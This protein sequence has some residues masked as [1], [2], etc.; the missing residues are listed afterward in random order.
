AV[1]NRQLLLDYQR[2]F[3]RESHEMAA[4]NPV[5]AYVFG[6]AFDRTKTRAFARLLKRHHIEVRHLAKSHTADNRHFEPGKAFVVPLDQMQYRLIQTFFEPHTTFLDSVFYDASAWTVA[7]AFDMP[8]ARLRSVPA[9]R[10]LTDE[11]LE[12]TPRNVAP[13]Q[14]AWVFDWSDYAAPRALYYLLDKG[15]VVRAATKPFMIKENGVERAFHYGSMLIALTDQ[16]LNPERVHDLVNEAGRLANIEIV[17][18]STGMNVAGPYLGSRAF[19]PVSKPRVAMVVGDG[20]SGYEAGEIWHLLDTQLGMPVTKVDLL[21]FDR[22]RPENY[23]A[24]I[25]PSGNYSALKQDRI[26]TLKNWASRGGTLIFMRQ[27]VAWAVRQGLVKEHFKKPPKSKNGKPRRFDFGTARDRRGALAVGGSIYLT[28]LDITHP[29]AFGYHRRQLPV[30]RNHDIFIEPSENPYSTV[31]QYTDAPLLDGYIHPDNLE[32]IK[33]S[34]SLLVSR[35]SR[36][37][38]ILFVDNPNF[39]GFWYGTNR[40]FF[41]ALFFAEL[42]DPPGGG[43]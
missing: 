2:D 43:E 38:A 36:G 32:M 20:I 31:A 3:F 1:D 5:K 6:D 11:D 22:L 39:R 25:F 15:V 14:Y 4:K 26:E 17:P 18:V 35:L 9:G 24:I 27:S 28:S 37:R 42:S 29:L 23:T 12:P 21:D 10:E 30:Y 7:L 16:Y 40:L 8:Y 19:V 41:N 34:A 33:N 13:T